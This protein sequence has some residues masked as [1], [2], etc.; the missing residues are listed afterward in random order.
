[1]SIDQEEFEMWMKDSDEEDTAP[2]E[3]GAMHHH[4]VDLQTAALRRERASTNLEEGLGGAH[5]GG[6][7]GDP[8]TAAAEGHGRPREAGS[9]PAA[10]RGVEGRAAARRGVMV[11]RAEG[12]HGGAG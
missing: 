9:G 4:R 3:R 5:G 1:M 7:T 12:E 11:L 10:R 8:L 2:A 6:S